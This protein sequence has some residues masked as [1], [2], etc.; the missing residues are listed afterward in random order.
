ML[1]DLWMGL[2][3]QEAPLDARR[4]YTVTA[5]TF[6]TRPATANYTTLGGTTSDGDVP[7]VG[8]VSR[9]RAGQLF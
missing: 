1:P 4:D 3:R 8:G 9:H 5:P 7:L 6:T 2:L